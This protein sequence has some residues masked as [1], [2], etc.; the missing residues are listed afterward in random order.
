M[1]GHSLGLCDRQHANVR[2]CADSRIGRVRS[3]RQRTLRPDSRPAHCCR[4][5]APARHRSRLLAFLAGLGVLSAPAGAAPQWHGTW[6]VAFRGAVAMAVTAGAGAPCRAQWPGRLE[7]QAAD[8]IPAWC[9]AACGLEQTSERGSSDACGGRDYE[10]NIP[11]IV[12]TCHPREQLRCGPLDPPAESRR[13]GVGR[14]AGARSRSAGLRIRIP[15]PDGTRDD[16]APH[17]TRR[18]AAPFNLRTAAGPGAPRS[19][20]L[21]R[22][23]GRGPPDRIDPRCPCGCCAAA[24]FRDGSRTGI[25]RNSRSAA[26]AGARR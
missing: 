25:R 12:A 8:R 3:R 23:P 9:A 20:H 26:C 13:V 10:Q 22:C 11:A 18:L 6:R 17:G 14:P 16:P 4:W 1:P 21:R 15:T 7:L 19:A 2:A 24:A 5:P